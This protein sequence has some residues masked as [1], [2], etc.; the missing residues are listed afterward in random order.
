MTRRHQEELI[1]EVRA[2]PV[3]KVSPRNPPYPQARKGPLTIAI[4]KIAEKA[5]GNIRTS[6]TIHLLRKQERVEATW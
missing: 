5:S 3:V 6:L 1:P 2:G 4:G